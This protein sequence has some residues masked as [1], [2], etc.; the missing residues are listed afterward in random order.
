MTAV[1]LSR[2]PKWLAALLVCA[3]AGCGVDGAPQPPYG[4]VQGTPALADE[5]FAD[6]D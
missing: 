5:I 4:A 3:V 2:A 1:V 6:S